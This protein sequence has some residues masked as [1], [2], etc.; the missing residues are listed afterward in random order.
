MQACVSIGIEVEH[1]PITMLKITSA[2]TVAF[3]TSAT[4][5]IQIISSILLPSFS[6]TT[7]DTGGNGNSNDS[8]YV[9]EKVKYDFTTVQNNN[10]NLYR[11]Q[12]ALIEV[13]KKKWIEI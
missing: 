11:I 10:L 6:S 3:L 7:T 4:K 2:N 13:M 8:K 12:N 9:E 1:S 5:P